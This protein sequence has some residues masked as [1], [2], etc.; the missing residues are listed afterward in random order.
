MQKTK[1]N[2]ACF[3]LFDKIFY[4]KD[5]LFN[6]IAPNGWINSPYVNFLHPSAQQQLNEHL[7]IM[8][9]PLGEFINKQD[10][11]KQK[12]IKD[13]KQDNLK[14]ISP[15]YEFLYA[16]GLACY[17]IFSNE[18][19]VVDS[20]EI[21]YD[22]GS[23]RGSASFVADYINMH[24]SMEESFDYLDFYLS[25]FIRERASLYEFYKFIFQVININKCDWVYYPY[26]IETEF[27][28]NLIEE[29]ILKSKV[30][31]KKTI[32]SPFKEHLHKLDSFTVLLQAYIAVFETLPK[33]II[34]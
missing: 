22:I 6:K 26:G 33:I 17:D 24:F 16:F 1:S 31:G 3:E 12:T 19:E 20:N 8:S 4:S 29:K 13:F 9:S 15:D 28:E 2:K 34:S 23:H 10:N 27:I 21:V 11:V 7:H 32:V 25:P 14:K 18:N 5:Y 30:E